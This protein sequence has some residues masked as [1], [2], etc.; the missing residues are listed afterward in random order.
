MTP[1]TWM[2]TR[3]VETIGALEGLSKGTGKAGKQTAPHWRRFRRNSAADSTWA[4][5]CP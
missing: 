4:R 3:L 2:N 5:S 1:H